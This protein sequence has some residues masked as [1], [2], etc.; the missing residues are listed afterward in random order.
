MQN[1]AAIISTYDRYPDA[2]AAVKTLTGAGFA[3]RNLGII[4]DGHHT[5]YRLAGWREAGDRIKL[6]SLGGVLCGGVGGLFLGAIF[7]P[8]TGDDFMLNYFAAVTVC[9]IEAATALGGLGLIAAI[10][11]NAIGRK[12]GNFRY[13]RVTKANSYVVI[14][15]GTRDQTDRGKAI[16]AAMCSKEEF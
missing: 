13:E 3:L 16:V 6:W 14:A 2:D 15:R 5:E 12:N 4:G 9:I 11:C 1:N 8:T 7:T 10:A